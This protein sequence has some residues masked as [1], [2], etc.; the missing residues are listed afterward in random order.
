MSVL[1]FVEDADDL[2]L[3]ALTF[4][5]AYDAEVDAIAFG[6]APPITSACLPWPSGTTRRSRS[7][8]GAGRSGATR[9]TGFLRARSLAGTDG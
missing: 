5:R 4:A 8:R 3:Q 1:V 7:S 2:A 6:A 9:S